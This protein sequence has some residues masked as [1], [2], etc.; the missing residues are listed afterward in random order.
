MLDS[1]FRIVI[2]KSEATFTTKPLFFSFRKLN[3]LFVTYYCRS[4]KADFEPLN[5]MIISEALDMNSNLFI[6]K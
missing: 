5:E 3:K 1:E 2:L 4:Y 6:S